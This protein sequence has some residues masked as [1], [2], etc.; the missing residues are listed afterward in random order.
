MILS[1]YTN[2][3][4]VMPVIQAGV[5]TREKKEWGPYGPHCVLASK[6][7]YGVSGIGAGR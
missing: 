1:M 7:P 2:I 5:Q 4:M 3:G 6:H